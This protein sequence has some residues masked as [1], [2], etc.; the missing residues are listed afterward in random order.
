MKQ[1]HLPEPPTPSPS[2]LPQPFSQKEA[3]TA[4]LGR[5]Q[6]FLQA[7]SH[8]RK[9]NYQ[10]LFSTYHAARPKLSTLS[11]LSPLFTRYPDVISSVTVDKGT[12]VQRH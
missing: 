5:N 7:E 11:V 2:T 3:S 12:E 4:H 1:P 8:S 6:A 9:T 10:H